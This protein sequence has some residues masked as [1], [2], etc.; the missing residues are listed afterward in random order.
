MRLYTLSTLYNAIIRTSHIPSQWKLA[1]IIMIPK[2]IK[3]P[4]KVTSY[5]LISLLT[6]MSKLF[7]KLLLV[8]M[9]TLVS[10]DKLIPDHQFGFRNNHLTIEAVTRVYTVILSSIGEKKY[11]FADFLEIQQAFGKV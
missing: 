5:R 8:R 10:A 1:R 3:P 9:K 2:S 11:C 7:E 4:N 6:I